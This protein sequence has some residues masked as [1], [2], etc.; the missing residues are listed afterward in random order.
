MGAEMKKMTLKSKLL[1]GSLAMVVLVM[2]SSAVVVS[3]VINMQN[4]A[5]SYQNIEKSMNIIRE[6]LSGIQDKLLA[7]ARQMANLNEMGSSL[8]FIQQFKDNKTMIINPLR[9]MAMGIGQVGMT[10]N[11][12][13][14]A[15][16]GIGG[17]LV[18]FSVHRDGGEVLQGFVPDAA[19]GITTGA[20]LKEGKKLELKDWKDLGKFQDP[21]LKLKLGGSIPKKETVFF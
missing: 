10:G 8:K 20:I 19:K 4:R 5:A 6:E 21:R 17:E 3:V 9:K 15:I 7:D 18:A 1:A 2:L 16:Y 14:T 13:K 11:L 12:W